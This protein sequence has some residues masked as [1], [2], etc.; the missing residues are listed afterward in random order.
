MLIDGFVEPVTG[1]DARQLVKQ[2]THRAWG[3][4]SLASQNTHRTRD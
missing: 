3:Q 4:L 2:P 1:A